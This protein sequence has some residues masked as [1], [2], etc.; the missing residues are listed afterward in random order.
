MSDHEN[1]SMEVDPPATASNGTEEA[2]APLATVHRNATLTEILKLCL[3]VGKVKILMHDHVSHKTQ[4]EAKTGVVAITSHVEEMLS[5]IVEKCINRLDEEKRKR[6]TAADIVAEIE[7]DPQ[8]ARL[9]KGSFFPSVG[10]A[11]V[12]T[13]PD[14]PK[15]KKA[16]KKPAA[17]V[18]AAGASKPKD[19]APAEVHKKKKE[20]PKPVEPVEEEEEDEEEEEEEEEAEGDE[21]LADDEEPI[22]EEEDEDEEQEPEDEADG[23][24]PEEEEEEGEGESA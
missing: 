18:P 19:K 6:L 4:Q 23:D 16:P 7:T 24:D 14:A 13:P 3:P 17:V 21:N 8:L 22:G 2:V 15:E 20:A 1:D 5:I 9:F 11:F 12:G 10:A